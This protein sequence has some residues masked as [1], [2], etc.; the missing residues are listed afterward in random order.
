MILMKINGIKHAQ[1]E[2]G[3]YYRNNYCFFLTYSN[4]YFKNDSQYLLWFSN[5]NFTVSKNFCLH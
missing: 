4:K 5:L 3:D 2:F 1:L